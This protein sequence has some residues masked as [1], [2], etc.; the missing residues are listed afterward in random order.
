MKSQPQEY[1][2]S[3]EDLERVLKTHYEHPDIDRVRDA[4]LYAKEAH[5]TKRRYSGA[6]YIIHPIA[7]AVRLAEMQLP[8]EIV[9]AGLLHDVPEDTDRTLEDVQ[10][11]FGEDIASMVAGVTK[12]GKVKYRGIDRY[13]ENLRKMFLAMAADVRVVF[14]KFADRLHNVETLSAMPEHKRQRV[15]KEVLEIYAPIAGRL[16]MGEMKGRLEDNA[17]RYAMPQEYDAA[18]TLFDQQVQVRTDDIE[19]TI[20]EARTQLQKA[21]IP[22]QYI[23]GRRKF[24]YSFWRKLQSYHGDVSKI[25]DLIAIRMIVDSVTDC[26]AALGIL[27]SHWV[28]LKGRIKDYIAQP[29]PNGYQSLH[30]TVLDEHCGIVEFQI[31]TKDMH[32]EAEFGVAAH[33]HY[34]QHG[35]EDPPKIPWMQDLID[36]HKEISSGKDF[37]KHLDEV[38]LDMFQDRI[39][40]LTP[41]GDVIDLPE[42]STPVDFAYHIHTDVGN[43]CVSASVNDHAVPLDLPLKSGDLCIIVTDKKRKGP[44]PDWLKF[45]KTHHAQS[46]IRAATRNR[47]R[48]W[49]DGMMGAATK[50][51]RI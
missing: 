35:S 4:Y 33:W 44:N 34:K 36:I 46:K 22:I 49:I 47:V 29:K 41:E 43:K 27:H 30:S 31:R 9:I 25:Y 20:A 19:F 21:H 15:A 28:P 17:F 45:V 40:V 37:L 13:A 48:Q 7:T 18:K 26:Y 23:S 2:W 50:T 16:G 39:F 10:E 6:S 24:L 42:G 14:I 51:K 11:A 8:L 5:G 1:L 3:F 32:N 38:K 12:L